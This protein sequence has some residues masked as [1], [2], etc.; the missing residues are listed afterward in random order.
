M[1]G[2]TKPS[3]FYVVDCNNNT[4][5]ED[6]EKNFYETINDTE[7]RGQNGV[8]TCVISIATTTNDIATTKID[9]DGQEQLPKYY[10]EEL[11]SLG[12]I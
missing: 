6:N 1:D 3:E 12:I 2:R 4:L 7:G 9:V 8:T 5:N 10:V 11:I